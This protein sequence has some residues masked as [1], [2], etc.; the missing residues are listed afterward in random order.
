MHCVYFYEYFNKKAKH[1][2]NIKEYELFSK[3]CVE[4]LK[5]N[6]LDSSVNKSIIKEIDQGQTDSILQDKIVELEM[7][8]GSLFLTKPPNTKDGKNVEVDDQV[9]ILESSKLILRNEITIFKDKIKEMVYKRFKDSMDPMTK[10][11]ISDVVYDEVKNNSKDSKFLLKKKDE[12]KNKR[13]DKTE[14]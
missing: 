13:I 7:S 6:V 11:S 5:I 14:L 4:I 2:E 3:I 1:Q 10:H 12:K 9:D 8:Q